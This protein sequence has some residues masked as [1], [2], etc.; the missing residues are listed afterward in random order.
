M[1]NPDKVME[2]P[3]VSIMP[4]KYSFAP[5]FP[6]RRQPSSLARRETSDE[7]VEGK[8]RK[9][10]KASLESLSY[11]SSTAVGELEGKTNKNY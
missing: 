8:G 9:R 2:E 5:L 3:F 4:L 6:L 1:H 11:T 10:D 7:G